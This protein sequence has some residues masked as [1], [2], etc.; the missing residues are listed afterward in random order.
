MTVRRGERGLVKKK[1][2]VENKESDSLLRLRANWDLDRPREKRSTNSTMRRKTKTT[3]KKK[4]Q[5]K[6][7]EEE[8]ENVQAAVPLDMAYLYVPLGLFRIEF[9]Y[10]HV[11]THT[12]QMFPWCLCLWD[13]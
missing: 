2:N 13:A 5:K 11:V 6:W 9:V 12:P 4:H 7:R 10:I 8:S 1:A 3:K